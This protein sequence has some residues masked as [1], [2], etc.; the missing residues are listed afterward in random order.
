M[1]PVW[2]VVVLLAVLSLVALASA[3][4]SFRRRAAANGVATLLLGV[5]LLALSGSTGLAAWSLARFEALARETTAAVVTVTPSGPQRFEAVV[6][7]ADGATRTFALAG[8]QLWVDAQIVK[9][10]PWANAIGLHTAYRLERIGGRYRSL[11]DERT[12]PRTVEALHDEDVPSDLFDW[13]GR[14]DWLRPLVD[15]SYGSA[16]YLAADEART[17][18]VRVS[19]SGLLLR[20]RPS[21]P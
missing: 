1:S 11:D 13:A 15:A 10:H 18:E 16:T 19:A 12:A 5:L 9:W 20:E 6:E 21:L 14:R 7:L 3:V 17:L 2:L 4:A 8:D